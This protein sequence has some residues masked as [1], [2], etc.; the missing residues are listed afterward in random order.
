MPPGA[1][2]SFPWAETGGLAI[3]LPRV[4]K[5]LLAPRL[6]KSA[7]RLQCT[8][9]AGNHPCSLVVNTWTQILARG[10]LPP[11]PSPTHQCGAAEFLPAAHVQG[12]CPCRRLGAR[13]PAGGRPEPGGST[14]QPGHL[15]RSQLGSRA[16]SDA[17]PPGRSPKEAPASRVIWQACFPRADGSYHQDPRS[18]G[19]RPGE[20]RGVSLRA[21]KGLG[22]AVAS[23]CPSPASGSPATSLHL[24]Q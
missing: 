19:E 24:H 3:K 15:H 22:K 9:R 14:A 10:P 2:T 20:N 4:F 16:A 8:S 18:P 5:L 1:S 21:G 7:H 23:A 11:G 12:Q 17:P 6:F 13:L